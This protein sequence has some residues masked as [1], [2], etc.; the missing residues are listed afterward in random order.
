MTHGQPASGAPPYLQLLERQHGAA[1]VDQRVDPAQLVEA[2]R[3][4][5]RTVNRGLCLGDGPQDGQRPLPRP[6]G[7]RA[8]ADDVP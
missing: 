4:H 7:Q 3:L 6:L 5:R 2:Y 8:A 1:D